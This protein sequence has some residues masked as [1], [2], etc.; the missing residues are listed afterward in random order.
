MTTMIA[1]MLL[2]TDRRPSSCAYLTA[3]HL[4]GIVGLITECFD[5]LCD[6]G[7]LLEHSINLGCWNR[8]PVG[9]YEGAELPEIRPGSG[10]MSSNKETEVAGS[11][12]ELNL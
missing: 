9:P 1:M 2:C 6:N 7:C 8:C 11:C 10:S 4:G 12:R 5:S 3:V